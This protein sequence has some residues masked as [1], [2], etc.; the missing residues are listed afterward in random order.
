MA[1]KGPSD[2]KVDVF[3][4]S[5]FNPQLDDVLTKLVKDTFL[6]LIQERLKN[7][8]KS[9]EIGK[10]DGEIIGTLVRE[11]TAVDKIIL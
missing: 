5:G 4:Q 11:F 8:E 6:T 1:G 3:D 7:I 9:Q 10:L 2:A